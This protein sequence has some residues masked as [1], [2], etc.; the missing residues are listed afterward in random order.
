MADAT[1]QAHLASI[2]Q[3]FMRG[4]MNTT[5]FGNVTLDNCNMTTTDNYALATKV[6]TAVNTDLTATKFPNAADTSTSAY[7]TFLDLRA[8]LT[9]LVNAG[10]FTLAGGASPM[11][12]VATKYAH[13]VD[14]C[15]KGSSTYPVGGGYKD[16]SGCPLVRDKTNIQFVAAGARP[17]AGAGDAISYDASSSLV[18]YYKSDPNDTTNAAATTRLDT[19]VNTY[20]MKRMAMYYVMNV[21]ATVLAYDMIM[22]TACTTNASACTTP[23]TNLDSKGNAFLSTLFSLAMLQYTSFN[24]LYSQTSAGSAGGVPVNPISYSSTSS[25]TYTPFTNSQDPVAASLMSSGTA[26]ATA[27]T[28]TTRPYSGLTFTTAVKAKGVVITPCDVGSSTLTIAIPQIFVYGGVYGTGSPVGVGTTYAFDISS[29]PANTA[30]TNPSTAQPVNWT[31]G[32]SWVGAPATY[33][34]IS[35]TAATPP[36]FQTLIIANG[37]PAGL[38]SVGFKRL[39]LPNFV[40]PVY[41][42]TGDSSGSSGFTFVWAGTE[43][44]L[45]PAKGA[46]GT[47]VTGWSTPTLDF[48]AAGMSSPI[49]GGAGGVAYWAGALK[50]PAT[51]MSYTVYP[52]PDGRTMPTGWTVS[53]SSIV[54]STAIATGNT[55]P[56]IAWTKVIDVDGLKWTDLRPTTFLLPVDPTTKKPSLT[57]NITYMRL[58][59]RYDPSVDPNAVPSAAGNAL[60]YGNLGFLAITVNVADTSNTGRPALNLMQSMDDLEMRYQNAIVAANAGATA[61]ASVRRDVTRGSRQAKSA[62]TSAVTAWRVYAVALTVTLAIVVITLLATLLQLQDR[63]RILAGALLVGVVLAVAVV[64]ATWMWD[65]PPRHIAASPAPVLMR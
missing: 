27:V 29:N 60:T 64:M 7:A 58:D 19:V 51:A 4:L 21:N 62:G 1:A 42:P 57:T 36:A 22:T 30:F 11:A 10:S 15:L 55:L 23:L 49:V 24:D 3:H 28:N 14:Y 53:V 2:N 26:W 54:P 47:N 6:T 52:F 13:V 9:S 65:V 41:D 48:T 44:L 12:D 20:T 59:V 43:D 38:A 33:A 39:S 61:F 34:L 46:V 16:T 56:V 25:T 63:V 31:P 17:G 32:Q 35:S 40:T 8:H 5:E 50:A 45:Y 18:T 37:D